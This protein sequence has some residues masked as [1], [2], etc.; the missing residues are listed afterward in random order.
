MILGNLSASELGDLRDKLVR[1]RASAE[2]RVEYQA[3][4]VTRIVE[5]KSDSELRT[6]LANIEAR[7]GRVEGR[8]S[9][10]VVALRS[11]K[12]WA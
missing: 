1:A 4:G 11:E 7:L 2:R 8:S 5:F 6:A 10:N 9:V 3:N 12:G